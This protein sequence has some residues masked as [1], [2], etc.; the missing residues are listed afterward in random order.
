ML[1]PVLSNHSIK[2]PDDIT[3][4]FRPIESRIDV[5]PSIHPM[6]PLNATG[7]TQYHCSIVQLNDITQ[8]Y[9]SMVS[10]ND[11]AH[12]ISLNRTPESESPN[13]IAQ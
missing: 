5:A 11:I 3:Q 4:C 7:I 1:S 2:S 6:V 12:Y 9:N 10:L 13:N 8:G